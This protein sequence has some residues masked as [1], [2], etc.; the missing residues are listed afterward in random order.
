MSLIALVVLTAIVVGAAVLVV[1]LRGRGPK[2]EAPA[3]AKRSLRPWLFAGLV[4]AVGVVGGLTFL[5]LGPYRMHAYP[6]MPSPMLV[7][8]VETGNPDMRRRAAD[9]LLARLEV[10]E[11]EPSLADRLLGA[12]HDLDLTVRRVRAGDQTAYS[13]AVRAVSVSMKFWAR[14]EKRETLIDGKE[15]P[16]SGGGSLSGTAGASGSLGGV[17]PP[18]PAGR[19]RVSVRLKLSLFAGADLDERK[20]RKLHSREIVVTEPFEVLP[21]DSEP[22]ERLIADPSLE[23]A[24]RAAIQVKDFRFEVSPSR[25]GGM[26]LLQAPPVDVAFEVFARIDGQEYRLGSVR[27]AKGDYRV[28]DDQ[29]LYQGPKVDRLDIILRSSLDAARWTTD[30]Y[31]IWDGELEYRDVPVG[32]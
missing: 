7:Q 1:G 20:S 26:I 16:R 17:L 21:E 8:D 15:I 11:L 31:E 6:W 13:V 32:P 22:L 3:E 24:V 9:E 27:A 4:V 10:G 23:A 25:L 19:H 12:L 30:L 5:V 28:S 2:D 18:L 14:I 29:T